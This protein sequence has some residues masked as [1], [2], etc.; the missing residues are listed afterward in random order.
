LVKTRYDSL[1]APYKGTANTASAFWSYVG[2]TNERNNLFFYHPDHLGSSSIITHITKQ[3]VQNLEYV[4]FGEVFVD[5]RISNTYPTPFK[6]NAKELDEE[7]GLY[8]YGARYL[9]PPHQPLAQL[10]SAGRKIPECFK[11]RLLYK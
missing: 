3:I 1:N 4:P 11:L 6:F 5:E 7:T 9:D 8:F 2:V 10:R